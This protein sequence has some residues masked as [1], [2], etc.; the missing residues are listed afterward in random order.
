MK[1]RAFWAVAT[2]VPGIFLMQAN[3]TMAVA[4][5]DLDRAVAATPEGKEA[6]TKLTTFGNEQRTA[7]QNKV[8]EADDLENR[9]RTQDRVLSETARAEMVRNLDA[10]RTTIQT[11]QDEAQNKFTQLQKQLLGPVEQKTATAVSAYA[12]ER[13]LKIVFDASSL[14]NALVYVHDTADITT[15]IIRR[16]AANEQKPG[17]P[18]N[19][20]ERLQQQLLRRKW[21]DIDFMKDVRSRSSSSTIQISQNGN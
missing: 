1:A 9:L 16:I 6:I 21:M 7:I 20:S 11:M 17:S 19:A 2:L 4:V 14:G 3:G 15:E 18:L 10:T 12:A 13:G 8:K 5:I